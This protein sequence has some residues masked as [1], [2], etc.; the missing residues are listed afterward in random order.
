MEVRRESTNFCVARDRA[1]V[2]VVWGRDVIADDLAQLSEVQREVVGAYEHCVVTSIIRA[3]LSLAVK[4]DARKAGERNLA[5]F[6]GYTLGSAMVV[7]AGGLRASFFRSV[8]TGIQLVTRS[9]VPQKVFHNIDD[10]M[11]W[12]LAF[13]GVDPSTAQNVDELIAG[14]Y[15]LAERYGQPLG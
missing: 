7:E 8:V 10:S 9:A 11:R 14:A 12:L 6:E 2:V 15:A 4:E 13:P 1:L 3:G 5:E